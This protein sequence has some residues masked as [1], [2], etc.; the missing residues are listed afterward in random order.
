MARLDLLDNAALW[1]LAKS[2]QQAVEMER[3]NQLL[4]KNQPR[5][6]GH[7]IFDWEKFVEFVEINGDK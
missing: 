7:K 5:G 6:N 1:L 4:E 3:Y 2:H